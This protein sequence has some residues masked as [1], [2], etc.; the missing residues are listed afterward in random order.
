[1]ISNVSSVRN[2]PRVAAGTGRGEGHMPQSVS[3][4]KSCDAMLGPYEPHGLTT[5]DLT[6]LDRIQLASSSRDM[7]R[8][9]GDHEVFWMSSC[10]GALECPSEPASSTSMCD[11]PGNPYQWTN[12]LNANVSPPA[13]MGLDPAMPE[14]SSDRTREGRTRTDGHVDVAAAWSGVNAAEVP[15]WLRLP[16]LVLALA[17]V[18]PFGVDQLPGCYGR[19]MCSLCVLALAYS[20]C[21]LVGSFYTLV[22]DGVSILSVVS[23]CYALGGGL[24][25]YSLQQMK[26]HDLIGTSENLLERYATNHG[27]SKAWVIASLRLLVFVGSVWMVAVVLIV[28]LVASQSTIQDEAGGGSNNMVALTFSLVF[29][30]G[31]VTVLTYC[32]LHVCAGLGLMVDTF[33][34]DFAARAD[35]THGEAQWNTMQAVMHRAAQTIDLCF[36]SVQVSVLSATI[37]VGMDVMLG[38]GDHES[39][40]RSL[41]S[42]FLM[43]SITHFGQYRAAMVTQKCWQAPALMTS[44]AGEGVATSAERQHL[45]QCLL[46]SNAGFYVRGV[47]L[48][49]FMVL[50]VAYLFVIVTLGFAMRLARTASDP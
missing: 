37:L 19:F 28:V 50:K 5:E 14:M 3:L 13:A 24:G 35:L 8:L 20:L 7:W 45:I 42:G 10:S 43:M 2:A 11:W 32:Q 31:V 4:G 33:C 17:G 21:T 47:R 44:L 9:C 46:Q 48:T 6:E 22:D 38:S 1:L 18:L 41:P 29:V 27:F 16:H 12:P 49:V 15:Y 36:L 26:V 40:F 34:V 39:A 23:A 25:L 30:S